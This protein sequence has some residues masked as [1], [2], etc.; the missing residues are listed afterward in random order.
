MKQMVLTVGAVTLVTCASV[1]IAQDARHAF[2]Q[3]SAEVQWGPAPA[4]L[5][6]AAQG[7]VLHGDPVKAGP[8]ALRLKLPDGYRIPPHYHPSIQITVLEGTL[9]I[10]TGDAVNTR[11]EEPLR[12]GAFVF[13]PAG[14]RYFARAQGETVVELHGTA[15]WGITYVSASDD[16][17]KNQ[18]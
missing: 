18:H 12:A 10:G 13:V 4:S 2:I 3:S 16:P 11:T 9:V 5:P 6:P 1:V 17:R 7:A 15:P 8:F 14:L